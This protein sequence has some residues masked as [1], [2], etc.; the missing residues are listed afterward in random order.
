MLSLNAID[1][2]QDTTQDSRNII[3]VSDIMFLT[4]HTIGIKKYYFLLIYKFD[5]LSRVIY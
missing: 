4:W 1:E 5:V 3:Y 2:R